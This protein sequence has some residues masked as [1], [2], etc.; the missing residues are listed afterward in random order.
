[1]TDLFQTSV[2]LILAHQAPSGAYLASP[3]FPTYHYCWYRDGAFIAYAMDLAREH[4]SAARFHAWAAGAVNQRADI[5]QRAVAKAARGEALSGADILHT[6][7]TA[8]GHDAAGEDWP[9]FQLDGFGTWLWALGEHQRLAGGAALAPE[10]SQAA[11]LVADYLAALWPQPCYDCWEEFPDQVHPHTLAAIYGGLQAHTRL[12]GQDHAST[13]ADIRRYLETHAVID[14]HFAKFAGSTAVDASL[15]GLAIPYGVFAVDDPR[16][17][18][19]VARIESELRQG[20]GVHRYATDTYYGGGEWLLLT[21]WLGWYY[22]EAG[23]L[24]RAAEA[25]NWVA[26]Q[27]D[28]NG[29]LAE[30]LPRTLNDAAAYEPWR[31]RWGDVANPL[32]WSHAKYVILSQRQPLTIRR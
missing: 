31:A 3:N 2:A 17:V 21:A 7:Y 32:L 28:P 24:A 4:A 11:G 16:V 15:L 9:N 12:T 13:L 5:V 14:G 29:W 23:Q 30:Q 27:A 6:R 10:W 19:T 25:T 8:D 26:A 20:G 18:R 22:A 1:M